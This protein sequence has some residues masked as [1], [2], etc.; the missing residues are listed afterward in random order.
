MKGKWV[1]FEDKGTG[2]VKKTECRKMY[3]N[4]MENSSLTNLKNHITPPT[5]VMTIV[6]IMYVCM[7][8]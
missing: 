7:D 8:L 1:L 3:N 2:V 5:H 4:I 6:I